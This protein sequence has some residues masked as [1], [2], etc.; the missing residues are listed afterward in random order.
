MTMKVVLLL[1]LAL[2]S[3][4]ANLLDTSIVFPLTRNV[5]PTG[6]FFT[7]T[8]EIGKPS[9]PFELLIDTGSILT[10]VQCYEPSEH[11]D[12]DLIQQVTGHCLS[13]GERGGFLFLGD[14][15][16]PASG[17]SWMPITKNPKKE[18]LLGPADLLFDELPTQ[19]NRLQFIF[20]SGASYSY[21]GQPSYDYTLDQINK[22]LEGTPL[23]E[24]EPEVGLPVCWGFEKT[25]ISS[26]NEIKNYFKK[27]TLSFI[28]IPH[29]KLDLPLPAYLTL[30]N[31]KVCLGIQDGDSAELENPNIIGA[32]S[33]QN[34]LMIYDNVNHRIGW[35]SRN[36]NIPLM[37]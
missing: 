26:F 29:V 36:C 13:D 16:V 9:K 28:T 35:I 31:G 1:L 33:M 34:K 23:K 15:L 12:M 22:N 32:I 21:L 7:T 6:A 30:V 19:V 14:D 5:C 3:A 27:L 17:V 4:T 25:H 8:I 37:A 10:W 2:H 20:D 24:S 18:Y 11:D